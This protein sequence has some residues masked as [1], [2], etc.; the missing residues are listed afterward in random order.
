MSEGPIHTEE[1]EVVTPHGTVTLRVETWKHDDGTLYFHAAVQVK[2]GKFMHGGF[3]R[4]EIGAF[5]D[6]PAE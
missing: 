1:R 6:E 2:N 5:L 3:S 4:Y